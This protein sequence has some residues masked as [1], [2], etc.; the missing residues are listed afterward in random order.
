MVPT[1]L[2][3]GIYSLNHVI[4]GALKRGQI[5]LL[6]YRNV[7]QNKSIPLS[8]QPIRTNATSRCDLTQMQSI[9]GQNTMH[10]FEE[11]PTREEFLALLWHET[12]NSAMQKDW[13]DN[14]ISA[15]KKD[16]NGPFGISV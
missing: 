9:R 10:H 14:S 4:L 13:I 1:R 6:D 11:H 16:P 15:S 3:C 5:Y 8:E 2:G 12:I 7:P